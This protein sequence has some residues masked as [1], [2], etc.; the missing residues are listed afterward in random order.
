M[1]ITL[2]SPRDENCGSNLNF[3]AKTNEKENVCV[4]RVTCKAASIIEDVLKFSFI[5][6]FGDSVRILQ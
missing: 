3:K 4:W 1:K 5:I 6:T 2:Y